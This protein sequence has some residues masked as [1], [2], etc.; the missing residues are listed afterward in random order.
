MSYAQQLRKKLKGA[1]GGRGVEKTELQKYLNEGLEED[2]KDVLTWWKVHGAR[3][4]VVA[5]MA[6]DVL[7]VPASTVALKSAFSACGCTLDTFRTSLTP[8]V[9]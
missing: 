7:A 5:H 3:Y 8:K 9:Y 2:D 1:D 4:P 6:H